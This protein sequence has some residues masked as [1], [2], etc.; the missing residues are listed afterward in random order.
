MEVEGHA[1]NEGDEEA[2]AGGEGGPGMQA[3]GTS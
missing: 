1:S 3:E 2:N